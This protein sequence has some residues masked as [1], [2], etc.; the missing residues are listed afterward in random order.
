MAGYKLTQKALGDVSAALARLHSEVSPEAADK[1]ERQLFVAFTELGAMPGIGHRRAD[2][3][4]KNV[5]FYASR[6]YVIV[7]RRMKTYV[8]VLHVLHERQDIKERIV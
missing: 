6:P 2:L 7:L 1:L 8:Q 4:A 5:F 3:T